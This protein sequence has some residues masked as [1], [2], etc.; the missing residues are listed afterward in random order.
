MALILAGIRQ[1]I[2]TDQSFE[3]VSVIYCNQNVMTPS[4]IA[5]AA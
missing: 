2:A 1:A 3:C 5:G 4:G